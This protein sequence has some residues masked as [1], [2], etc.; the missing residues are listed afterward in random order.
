MGWGWED[1]ESILS[2]VVY[3][4]QYLRAWCVQDCRCDAQLLDF[5]SGVGWGTQS[6][7]FLRSLDH[8]MSAPSSL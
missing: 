4:Y 8:L 3:I 6:G 7:P 1:L 5:L 2:L